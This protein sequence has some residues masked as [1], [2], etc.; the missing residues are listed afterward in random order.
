MKNVTRSDLLELDIF[1]K[2]QLVEDI[3]DSI[4]SVSDPIPFTELQKEE[5]ERYLDVYHQ[6]PEAGSPWTL[7]GEGIRD[8]A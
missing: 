4:V 3:W 8:G 1:E 5:L 2:I 7:V 6:N